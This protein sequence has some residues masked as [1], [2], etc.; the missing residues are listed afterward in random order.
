MGVWLCLW[1]RELA[2]A[3]ENRRSR[4]RPGTRKNRFGGGA[5]TH[6]A[7]TR[8][9]AGRRST[10]YTVL[11]VGAF[12][13]SASDPINYIITQN[14]SHP[15]DPTRVRRDPQSGLPMSGQE[16]REQQS[17]PSEVTSDRIALRAN[18]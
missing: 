9:A 2:D 5:A 11:I 6:S 7:V 14:G 10:Y 16:S 4:A 18:L 12:L 15:P 3:A 8:S 1:S 17:V 13:F